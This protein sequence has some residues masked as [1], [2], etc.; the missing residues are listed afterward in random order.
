MA[1]SAT[2]A[3]PASQTG[4][5]AVGTPAT[6]TWRHPRFEEIARRQKATTFSDQNLSRV[7]WN[8]GALSTTWLL[9]WTI[10]GSPLLAPLFEPVLTFSAYPLFFLR[11]LLT[12][13]ILSAA[14]PLVR[15]KD[16]LADIPLTP[17]Q[18]ALLGLDPNAAPLAA[19][20][21]QFV[22]PPRYPRSATPGSG[23]AGSRSSGRTGS[24][25]SGKGSPSLGRM[26]GGS[27]YSTPGSPLWQKAVGGG[28]RE[29]G[30]KNSYGS[31]SPFGGGAGGNG[32]SVMGAPATPSPTS[33]KGASVGLNSRWLYE[34]GR[35]S[36][37]GAKMYS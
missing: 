28:T 6:G 14:L 29:T 26:Q 8:A 19:S 32:S 4:A 35:G 12:F 13:N 27:P 21:A 10:Q 36:P 3:T 11:L 18:R 24:P 34:R 20:G 1:S 33:G 9:V 37:G 15:P 17:S 31:P 30:R 23:T 22:T 16:D 2:P 25:L 7:L 5:S